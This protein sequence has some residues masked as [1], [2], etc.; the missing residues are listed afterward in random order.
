[1]SSRS[2]HVTQ[3]EILG[4][5]CHL[6]SIF[7]VCCLNSTS[8]D[9]SH[10]GWQ[11]AK[12]YALKVDD[13]IEQGLTSWDEMTTVVGNSSFVLAQMDCPRQALS[14][15]VSNKK[16]GIKEVVC[17]TFNRCLTK[18]KCEYD[19]NAHGAELI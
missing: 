15:Q 5:L 18:N 4:N 10:Y 14:K 19:T 12:D 8:V 7:E 11:I 1:M 17:T 6:K 13:E 3:G 9:F 2:N 16:E